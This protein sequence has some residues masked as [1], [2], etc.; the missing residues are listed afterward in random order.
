MTTP[1]RAATVLVLRS[2]AAAPPSAAGEPSIEVLLVRRGHRASFMANAYVFPGGRVDDADGQPDPALTCARCAARELHEEAALRVS[3][4]AELVPFAR[5]ITPSA[6]PKRFD[7]DFFLWAMPEDQEPR[8]DAQE[9]FDLRWLTPEA[10]IAAYTHDG[11]N[12]PPPT[13]STLED[14]AAEIAAARRGLPAGESLLPH[15]L[16]RCRKRVPVTL[17]PR[18]RGSQGGGIEIVMPWDREFAS[19][20]GEGDA[21]ACLALGAEPVENRISRCALDPPGIWR[22]VRQNDG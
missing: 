5:W 10:A 12:L 8:V 1:R 14:L 22:F 11:L 4:L 21:A 19:T 15:L 13:V 2:V 6:E 18:L 9:V 16:L 20:P 7:T 17:L 3:D